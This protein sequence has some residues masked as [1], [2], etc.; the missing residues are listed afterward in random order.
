MKKMSDFRRKTRSHSLAA[1]LTGFAVALFPM[2]LRANP[3]VYVTRFWHNHQPIYWPDWNWNG[4]QTG[5]V[6]YAWDS[7]VLKPS[8]YYDT[9][10]QHPENNLSEIFGLDDRR[11]AYQGRPRDSLASINSAGGFQLSYSGSLIDNVR[12]LADNNQLGYGSGW[13]N[14]NREAKG[15]TTPSGSRRLDLVGF[16][17]HHSIAPLIPKSVLRKELQIF[18]QAWW[19][20]WNG[21]PN[22]S[23]HSK[24]FFPTEMAFSRHI[25]DVLADEGYEW[26]IVASHHL[27]RTCPTYLNYANPTGSYNIYS[28]P[29]NRADRLGPSPTTG[30]WYSEPNPGNAAW[31]V[32]PFAYQ[33][34]KVKYVNPETGAEKT[35]IAVPSDDVLSYRYGY[36]NEGISKI[37]L[38]IS[39][40]AGDSSRPV[41][42]MPASDGDNAWG[43]GFSSWMEATPQFFS[44]S[45]NAGYNICVVQDFVNQFGGNAITSHVEDGAWIFPEMDYGSPYFLKW[46]EPPL[47]GVGASNRYPGT[48]ADLETPGFALKFYSWAPVIAAANWCETAEQIWTNESGSVQAWKIQAPYDWDGS[49]TSP[50]I[51]ELAWH[52]YLAGLD[53]GFNYYGGLGNDDEVKPSL[54]ARRAIELLQGYMSTRTNQDF[55]PPT[56]LKP[57]RFPYNPGWYTFGWFNSYGS[58][59]N[60]AY[61]KKMPSEFYIW[62]HAY[63]ISGITS[64]VVKVRM[65]NDGVNST[66]NNQN[67]T[68]AGRSDVGGWYSVAMTKRALPNDRTTL[69]AKANNSQID[70]FV[71]SPQVADYY[72]AKITDSSVP[73]FRGKLLDYY[74]EA[75]DGRGNVHRSD[76]QHVFVED[77]GQGGP[78]PS[79]VQFSSDPND[80]SPLTVT[81]IAA[82]GPLSNSVPVKMWISFNG[83]SNFA[84]YTMTHQGGGTST[85]TIASVPDNAPSAIVYFQ[86]TAETITDNNNGQNWSATIRDCDA[87]SGPSSVVFSNAPAC[88]P[89]TVTYYPNAGPLQTATQIFMHL[90]Y[91][92]WQQVYPTQAMAKISNNMWRITVQPPQAAT[93]IDMVFNNGAGTWDNNNGQDWHFALNVCQPPVIPPGVTITNPAGPVYTAACETAA[94]SLYGT[95]GSNV[96]GLMIWTNAANGSNGLRSA[97]AS[98]TISNIPLNIGTNVITVIGTNA[99]VSRTTNAYDNAG[100]AVYGDGWA[101]SDNGG[102]GFGA[103]TFYTS[104]GD[105]NQNGRFIASNDAVN[106]GKPAWGLYA[107][108]GNLSE[109]KR[110][111]TNALAV[112]QTFAF[113][114]DNGWI[115]NGGGI[116][117]ALQNTAGDTLWEFYFNGGE[118]YYVMNGSQTDIGWT[119]GGL[120]VQFTLT[121]STGYTVRITPFG[122]PT[123]TNSGVLQA[124]ADRN[125]TRFRAWNYNAGGGSEYD[126]FINNLAIVST[127]AAAGSVTSATITV[128]RP[129][130]EQDSNGDGIPDSWCIRYGF[131]PNANIAGNDPDGDGMNNWEEYVAD[132]HPLVS[133]SVFTNRIDQWTVSAQTMSLQVGPPTT[134]SRLYDVWVS[135]SLVDQIW[136][137]RNLNVPGATDGGALILTVTNIGD[138]GFYRTGVKLP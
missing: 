33:L 82:G 40:F 15:W 136:Q 84:G 34:H 112:G 65:D 85:Y 106:I 133:A 66:A 134:N 13:W 127:Q 93:Q 39:P 57:Q 45:Q 6:Q 109:V 81:Y 89:V 103:W 101:E 123:R 60:A 110:I 94:V 108:N 56:V 90:G 18:K 88:D 100:A 28:S 130:C 2:A 131:D 128:I 74:V 7:I 59:T 118:T 27:S 132:T 46:I 137:S 11:S 97:S 107:N 126:Y 92:G 26:A 115:Q 86:N 99:G 3:N 4:S 62:T 122:G 98:W 87:P 25:V 47:V 38:Y 75:Y 79:S 80:C 17:Y 41:I 37:G 30:W 55:T 53:S 135:T 63:D 42:V 119:D 77:D 21:N 121:S 48:Q 111:L 102:V 129:D 73:G 50:N 54:A 104:S 105:V 16:T 72:F 67:E 124:A 29:P 43:G 51:V 36:A 120:D 83:G 9:S 8:Q 70:Y 78:P 71:T 76:I 91:N 64:I 1:A 32:S 113:Q 10:V 125:I 35:I 49:W 114:M 138:S 96:V 24:G 12:N 20:A 31:N 14:G 117:A 61:L 68:Y 44:D 58:G 69:N 23:D 95:A 116:G 22:L 5:R 52:M 19:K